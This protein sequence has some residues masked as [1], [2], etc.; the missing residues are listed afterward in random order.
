[1]KKGILLR[2]IS[3]AGDCFIKLKTGGE[4]LCTTDFS[5]KYIRKFR[6]KLG[7]RLNFKNSDTVLVF[8]W[9]ENKFMY[10]NPDQVIGTTALSL[11][12]KNRGK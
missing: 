2:T 9:D 11:V 12:L 4:Y 7:I 1:M 3:G 10:I 5:T 6:K 8:N